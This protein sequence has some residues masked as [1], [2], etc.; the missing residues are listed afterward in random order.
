MAVSKKV[1]FAEDPFHHV[2]C[3]ATE[4][5]VIFPAKIS[6]CGSAALT[7]TTKLFVLV[8]TKC[9]FSLFITA[10]RCDAESFPFLGGLTLL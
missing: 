3:R 6:A 5:L 10:L 4:Q 9:I 7:A 1:W 2:I 8:V